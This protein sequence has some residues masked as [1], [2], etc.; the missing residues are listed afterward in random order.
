VEGL[1]VGASAQMCKEL[2]MVQRFQ[3]L[4][5]W[6]REAHSVLERACILPRVRSCPLG[7]SKYGGGACVQSA[8]ASAQASD[9][10]VALN[11]FCRFAPWYASNQAEIKPKSSH[12]G[13]SPEWQR[14]PADDEHHKCDE[15]ADHDV[16]E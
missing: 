1:V 5:E 8:S 13:C 14:A 2:D 10:L 3:P 15:Q 12:I 4:W 11:R 9:S 6:S 16:R 7:R